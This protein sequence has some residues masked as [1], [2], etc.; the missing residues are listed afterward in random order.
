M[1]RIHY[2]QLYN[3]ARLA[4]LNVLPASKGS[5]IILYLIH[6]FDSIFNSQSTNF[7]SC[8]DRTI[9][10]KPKTNVSEGQNQTKAGFKPWIAKTL[11]IK[12]KTNF[13]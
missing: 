2:P 13:I 3:I 6:L 11:D 9:T 4:L 12:T 1:I 8:Q 10:P 7:Q 5:T